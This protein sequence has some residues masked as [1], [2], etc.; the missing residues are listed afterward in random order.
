MS[1]YFHTLFQLNRIREFDLENTGNLSLELR[2]LGTEG[3]QEFGFVK[4][5]NVLPNFRA[6]PLVACYRRD[7]RIP[8]AERNTLNIAQEFQFLYLTFCR[9]ATTICQNAITHYRLFILQYFS[10]ETFDTTKL[11]I[12]FAAHFVEKHLDTEIQ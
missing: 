2:S 7:A 9:A 10:K 12:I 8:T 5:P 11:T 1:K 3:T 4:M 6:R